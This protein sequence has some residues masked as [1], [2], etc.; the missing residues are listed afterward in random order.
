MRTLVTAGLL[1][2]LLAGCPKSQD[3]GAP[4]SSVP[5]DGSAVV[6]LTPC[7]ANFVYHPPA[8]SSPGS[9]QV[10]GDWNGFAN[11]GTAMVGPDA[12]GAFSANVI[13]TP[14]LVGYKFI[15]DGTYIL[16]PDEHYQKYEQGIANSALVVPRCELPTLNSTTVITRPAAGQGHFAATVT[17][18]DGQ[19]APDMDPA[20]VAVTLRKDGVTTAVT[21]ATASN[22]NTAISIDIPNLADGKYTVF[23][24]AQD[25]A[26]QAP[27]EPL[28][29][30]FWIEAERFTWQDAL[31]YMVMTDR[32]KDGD[33]SNNP[34][35]I[36]NVDP[37]EDY[38]GGDLKGVTS[39]INDGTFDKLGITV[40]WLS[41]FNQNPTD[42]YV[43]SDNQ[44]LVSGFHGYWPTKAREVD[45]RF[46]T[47]DDLKAMVAAAH[48]HGIRVI[49]DLVVQHV[50]S[51][52][53]YLAT[54]PEWFN[55]TGCICGT[56]NC[57]WTVHRLDCLFTSYLPNIDW[58]NTEG[59]AQQVADAIWWLDTFDLDGFRMD[60]VKQVPDIA[61]LNLVSSVRAE[62]E[63]AGTP[64][65]MTGETAM[66]WGG[67]NLSDSLPDYQLISNYITPD[68]LNG[69]FDFVLYYAVPL[70]VFAT[71]SKGMPH[72]DYWVTESG[73][74]YP[75]GSIMSPYIGSQD[76]ARF[77]TLATYA[78]NSGLDQSQPYNQWDNIASAVPPSQVYGE[79][80][81][82]L[83]WLMTLPGAPMVYYGDEYGETGGVDP[84][85]RV[86]W[87]GDGTLTSDEQA[88]LAWSRLVGTAR[89]TLP[90]LRRG[91]YVSVYN[92]DENFLVF[93]RQDAVGDVAL[94][95]ISRN[96]TP[97]TV[98]VQLPASLGISNNTLLHDHLGGANV[99]VTNNAI[100]VTLG[101]Q[102][103]AILAAQ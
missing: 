10:T 8:G 77:A 28:R 52:H 6:D 76:T 96:L 53:E 7:V 2:C 20:T 27:A 21:T 91:A 50:H 14:G 31:L 90:A 16:D 51:D 63:A 43:A 12:N 75:T 62:F 17:F 37:R 66:G 74:Q 81:L 22:N 68:G 36:P 48:A 73:L 23:V 24:T 78:N 54:H 102:S 39:K 55:T 1:A 79:Q 9:V 71:R 26:H 84:N 42:A 25:Q 18:A 92:T 29:L 64:V 49:Q 65:F 86:N 103:A 93:A 57:D 44:H 94:V 33:P 45:T 85:N 11:P 87:R 83:T 41:P 69:Q 59:A 98:T 61:V 101:A 82:A 89:K 32:F 67:D 95:A 46:G 88:T 100:T 15:V 40:L 5:G 47:A 80:R 13:A 30:V 60:A 3:P 19:G 72:A 58:T 70:N 4:D 56:D 38:H 34:A 99:T 97:T 35:P